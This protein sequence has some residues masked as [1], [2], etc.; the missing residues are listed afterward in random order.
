MHQN[1]YDTIDFSLNPPT[2]DEYEN[3]AFTNSSF[4]Q[5]D[6]ADIVFIDGTFDNCD[7]SILRK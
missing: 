1:R 4:L 7:I 6:F 5:T 3:C 2:Y